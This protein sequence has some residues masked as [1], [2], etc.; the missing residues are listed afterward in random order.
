MAQTLVNINKKGVYSISDVRNRKLKGTWGATGQ[1][2]LFCWGNNPEGMLGH[3]NQTEYSSPVQLPGTTWINTAGYSGGWQGGVKSDGTLWNWGYGDKGNLAQ[4]NRTDYSSP[5]QV[6]S[7]TNW[8]QVG[9]C[10]QQNG[11][12]ITSTGGLYTWG[13]TGLGIG[14]IDSGNVARSSPVQVGGSDWYFLHSSY[15]GEMIYGTATTAYALKTDGRLYSWGYNQGGALG[16]QRAPGVNHRASSPI[17]MGWNDAYLAD[18]TTEIAGGAMYGMAITKS[19]SLYG[20]GLNERGQLGTNNKTDYMTPTLV[21]GSWKTIACT[22]G[23][24][25]G[26]NNQGNYNS[27][28]GIREDGTLWSWGDNEYG[29]LGLNN[30]SDYSS[31]K[32]VGTDTNWALV[33]ANWKS[34]LATKTDGT[35]WSWGYNDKGQ[36]GQNDRTE[37]SSPRQVGSA[38]HWPTYRPYLEGD[39]EV[40]GPRGSWAA[41]FDQGW[42][43]LLAPEDY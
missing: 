16:A 36:L 15:P 3:N 30:K 41:G 9:A 8:I 26:A 19:G 18:W 39:N 43:V 38:T 21:P 7:G 12:A 22:G 37:Y 34:S 42:S 32:Q 27:S 33:A 11:G 29:Q 23:Y 25:S 6:G 24:F 35:L 14:R 40:L 4:N 17:Q 13:G 28:L 20:W 31:P 2:K 10:G 1:R 5:K